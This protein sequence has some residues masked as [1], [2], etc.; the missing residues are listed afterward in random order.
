VKRTFNPEF[1][2]R[3]DEI[4]IFDALSEEDLAKITRPADVG[5]S[6]RTSRRRAS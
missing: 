6:T 3:L 1:V 4:I 5:S 2:N